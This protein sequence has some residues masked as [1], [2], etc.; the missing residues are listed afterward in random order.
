MAGSDFGKL[1]DPCGAAFTL[2]ELSIVLVI[3]GLII[4]GVMVGRDLINTAT[5]RSQV[6]QI[7]KYNSAVNTF[8]GKYGCLPGDC[9]IA[10][11]YGLGQ[12]GNGDGAV[13][14]LGCCGNTA[15]IGFGCGYCSQGENYDFFYQLQQ[16]GL[17]NTNATGNAGASY[18]VAGFKGTFPQAVVLNNVLVIPVW[19]GNVNLSNG[20]IDPQ[21][22]DFSNGFF[23]G[24]VYDGGGAPF[25]S[26]ALS[27]LMAGQIDTKVDDG[28]PGSGNVRE[29]IQSTTMV[30]AC[31]VGNCWPEAGTC[32]NG[33]QYL[34][35]NSLGCTLG[36]INQF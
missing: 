24:F 31:N 22:V 6:S 2:V 30:K 3:I 25:F 17:V 19:W 26:S 29:G 15:L 16:A 10:A 36:F 14:G 35:T 11:T 34:A 27:P 32:S 8:H 23:L 9:A 18:T 20:S 28:L 1:R 7:E 4:G 33:T 12:N 13:G 5:V 21:W